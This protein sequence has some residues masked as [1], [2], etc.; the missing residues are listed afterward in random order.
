MMLGRFLLAAVAV[1]VAGLDARAADLTAIKRVIGKEPVY[2]GRPRY[3]L[4]V[5]GPEAK[6]RIWMVRDDRNLYMDRDSTGDLAAA[7]AKV[8]GD[9]NRYMNIP[10]IGAPGHRKNLSLHPAG[11]QFRLTLSVKGDERQYVGIGLM[12]KPTWGD[13]AEN[14][15]IIHFDGP[16]SLAQYGPPVNVPRVV[17]HRRRAASLRLL[18]GT[19]G[20]GKGTFASY[21]EVCTQ[22]LG[23]IDAEITF[24]KVDDKT[25]TF[26]QRCELIHD[27]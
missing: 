17:D 21:D 8:A 13:K 3:C 9:P 4:L 25:K 15:P 2:Q 23:N 18:V 7:G 24:T 16:M 19:P 27:G 1:G 14:A 12:E 26:T 11:D 5:F 22:N 20:L 6:T 10:D